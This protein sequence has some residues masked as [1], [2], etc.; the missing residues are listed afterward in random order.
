MKFFGR[1]NKSEEEPR[2]KTFTKGKRDQEVL[3]EKEKYFKK[4]K[5]KKKKFEIK[6]WGKKERLFVVGVFISTIFASAFLGMSSREWKLPNLPRFALPKILSDETI[7]IEGNPK[8]VK[9]SKVIGEFEE[10]TKPLSGV[11]G[12]F[13]IRLSDNSFYGANDRETF[14]AASLNK[15]PV[16]LTM[17]KEAERGNINLSQ[18]YILKGSDKRE[19]SGSLINKPAGT[20]LTY[21]DLVKY[22]GHESDNTA[23]NIAKNILGE[24]K[25][26]S[27]MRD[28]NLPAALLTENETTPYD[29]GFFWK[30]V[31]DANYVSRETRDALL[32]FMTD[33]VYENW[34]AKDIPV[35]VVHK[36]GSL[37]H[38]RNDA[39]VVFASKPYILVV[40]SKGV[41]ESQADEVIPRFAR[42][43]YDSESKLQ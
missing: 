38:I 1:K 7:V 25:I 16:M 31:M 13:V 42:V 9:E 20:A 17:Y 34:I 27:V 24:E 39:G 30:K 23:F 15:L 35:R 36:Y 40:M 41:V 12:F 8:D 14:D 43:V 18:K 26:L 33:T 28:I 22:M 21:E 10:L 29:I 4:E 6:P 32:E 5:P 19:G 37:A 3:S 11:Y 2:R